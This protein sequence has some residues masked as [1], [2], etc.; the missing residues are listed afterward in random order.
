[1]PD[2]VIES[3]EPGTTMYRE[4]HGDGVYLRVKPSGT[5]DWQL[6]Y[7]TPEGKWGWLGI[8]GYGKGTHQ[9]TG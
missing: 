6:R 4:R 7:K 5:K 9:L 2:T 3:I 8:G 1:M